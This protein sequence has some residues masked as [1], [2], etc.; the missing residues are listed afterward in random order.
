MPGRAPPAG[1]LSPRTRNLD[2]AP[3]EESMNAFAHGSLVL[4]PPSPRRTA[5]PP[6]PVRVDGKQF[7]RGTERLRVQGVTYG[8]FAPG[9]DGHQFP[10]PDRVA[11]DFARMGDIGVNA[12]RTYHVPPDWLFHLADEAGV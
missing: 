5:P 12:V 11:D 2:D 10:T 1:H 7:A 8:P 4:A 9:A 6:A 3:Y